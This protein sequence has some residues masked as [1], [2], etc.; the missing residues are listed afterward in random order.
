MPILS[1]MWRLLWY[2]LKNSKAVERMVDRI[3]NNKKPDPMEKVLVPF[4]KGEYQGALVMAEML[5]ENGEV[6]TA[7]AFFRGT[8]NSVTPRRA[9]CTSKKQPGSILREFGEE[10]RW[11]P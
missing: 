6:T 10:M 1:L 8:R 5:K 11:L 3:G 7:Y 2:Y 9:S 4:R